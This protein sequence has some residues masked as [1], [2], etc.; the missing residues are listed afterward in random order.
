MSLNLNMEIGKKKDLY[1][2]KKT[3]NLCYQ[4]K[5]SSQIL[6]IL[7]RVLF[8]VLLVAVVLKLF[9]VDYIAERNEARKEVEQLQSILDMQLIAIQDYDEVA[10]EYARYSYKLLVDA[11]VTQDRLDILAMLEDT[12]FQNGGMSNVTI[13]GNVVSLS[14]RGLNLDEC[15]DL[16]ADIQA[17]EMVESVVIS[18]QEGSIGGTY[19][20]N[21]S[22][23]LK[24]KSVEKNAGGER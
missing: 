24:P 23:R 3:I 8:V 1:P 18:N 6:S 17:Y 22:I 12:V 19:Q 2:S 15:A 11:L 10:E 21:L 4:E 7:I 13:S 20:G 5:A 16:L 14:F 9:V